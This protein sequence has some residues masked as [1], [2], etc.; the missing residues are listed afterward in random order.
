[1]ERLNELMD[2]SARRTVEAIYEFNRLI[3]ACLPSA[4]RRE[5]RDLPFTE[6]ESRD[7]VYWWFG[8]LV[9]VLWSIFSTI[10]ACAVWLYLMRTTSDRI[11]MKSD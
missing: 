5:A 4:T 10:I 1:M 8:N 11:R 6:W 2:P 7:P 3:S 9:H